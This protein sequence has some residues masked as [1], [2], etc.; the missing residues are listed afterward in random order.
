MGIKIH[1]KDLRPELQTRLRK[2][3]PRAVKTGMRLGAERGRTM[4]VRKTP[5]SSG[6]M[7]SAWKVRTGRRGLPVI[8]NDAPHAGI[9]EGGARPHGVNR[10]GIE[11][12][13]QWALRT[14]PGADEKT[15]KNIVWGTVRKLKRQG[16]RPTYF[17]RDS[18]DDLRRFLSEAINREL[19]KQ[20]A[21][22]AR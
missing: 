13:T 14:F 8:E 4:L 18:M 15:I 19:R 6:Q 10:E 11:A 22:R 20:S 5:V 1:P 7:K 21:R 2:S 17:V 12:L 3:V 16:Q 9:V